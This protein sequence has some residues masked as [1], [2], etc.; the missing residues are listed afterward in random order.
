MHG[1]K[2]E[3]ARPRPETGTAHNIQIMV[4]K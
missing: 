3:I 4:F 2:E 1:G